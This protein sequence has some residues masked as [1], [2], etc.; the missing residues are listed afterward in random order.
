MPRKSFKYQEEAIEKVKDLPFAMLNMACG[1]GKTHTAI[2][3]AQHKDMP[4]IIIAPKNV[5]SSW[6]DELMEEGV[7]E[8]DIWV[9]TA[10]DKRKGGDTYIDD[11]K[12]WLGGK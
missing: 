10:E 11:F 1:T 2:N 6:K 9:Y 4:T 7:A 3:I 8:E 12:K 5:L